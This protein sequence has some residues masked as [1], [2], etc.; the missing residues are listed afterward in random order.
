MNLD[1]LKTHLAFQQ[2]VRA[3]AEGCARNRP[4]GERNELMLRQG[5]GRS[6]RDLACR[7]HRGTSRPGKPVAYPS[8]EG[9]QTQRGPTAPLPFPSLPPGVYAGPAG[10]GPCAAGTRG[11][12]RG[13]LVTVAPPGQLSPFPAA[14][15]PEQDTGQTPWC[16]LGAAG[17]TLLL[18]GNSDLGHNFL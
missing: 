14:L 11:A 2:Q 1:V 8:W 7:R 16:A 10:P 15:A 17:N 13:T 18:A 4:A 5:N 9:G 3:S 12:G 6:R